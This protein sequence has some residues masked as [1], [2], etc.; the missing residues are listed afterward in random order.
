LRSELEFRLIEE[1]ESREADAVSSTDAQ[2]AARRE[3]GNVTRVAEETRT[4]WG[5]M[6]VE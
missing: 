6:F 3:L 4:E 2:F 1:F 5:W